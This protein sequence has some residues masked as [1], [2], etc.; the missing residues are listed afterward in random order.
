MDVEKLWAIVIRKDRGREVVYSSYVTESK[1]R[2]ECDL[3]TATLPVVAIVRRM[4]YPVASGLSPP[5]R[6]RAA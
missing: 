1:A 3:L 2:A 5:R 4:P 6:R